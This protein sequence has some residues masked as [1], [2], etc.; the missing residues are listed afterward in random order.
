MVVSR[1]IN[2]K[3]ISVAV[4]SLLLLSMV[5]GIFPASAAVSGAN[6]K[7]TIVDQQP[8]PAEIGQYMDITVQVEN[9]GRDW[10]DDVSI[11]MEPQYPF[12]LD[13]PAN[14][15]QNIGALGP[16]K[17]ATKEFH[18]FIDKNSQ[19]G[20]MSIDVLT[21]NDKGDPWSEETFYIKVGSETFDSK[22][23]LQIEEIIFK[24]EVFMPGDSGMVTIT[25]KNTA[26][27]DIVTIDG[28]DYDTDARV[29]SARLYSNELIEVTTDPKGDMGIV[30]A[31]DSIDL[32][33][34]IEVSEDAGPGTYQL[35]HFVEGNSHSYNSRRHVPVKVDAA[36]VTIV[37]SKPLRIIG[38]EGTLEFDVAN[39]NPNKI[40]RAHV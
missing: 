2:L 10:A 34:N 9:V 23:T 13:S 15:V 1:S 5:A 4:I 40:G 17:I 8:Y 21:Q 39:M 25:L 37:P 16:E 35:E 12:S 29:Q 32:I 27:G 33:Y 24:P 26:T 6:L 38:G 30:K 18:L 3:I 31:G 22:G 14:A 7:V 19:K 36:G 11:K 28:T 20:T